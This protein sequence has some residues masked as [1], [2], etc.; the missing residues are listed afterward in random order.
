MGIGVSVLLGVIVF[1]SMILLAYRF[2]QRKQRAISRLELH[3]STTNERDKGTGGGNGNGH[4]VGY[5]PELH[6]V[7][8]PI[9]S[10]ELEG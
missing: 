5:V 2:G 4:W 6:G 3:P 9:H 1:A 10:R 8:I 7:E